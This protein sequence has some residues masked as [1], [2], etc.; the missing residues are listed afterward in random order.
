MKI[1]SKSKSGSKSK[2][3]A[4]GENDDDTRTD[5][6]SETPSNFFYQD[7]R[8]SKGKIKLRSAVRGDEKMSSTIKNKKEH[9]R[10]KQHRKSIEP[11]PFRVSSMFKEDANFTTPVRNRREK[12][13]YST[14]L[15]SFVNL[16]KALPSSTRNALKR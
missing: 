16:E 1:K 5:I 14:R 10:K 2:N 7:L 9:Q 8:D 12:K 13:S 3:G 11:K 15:E 4:E 6:E